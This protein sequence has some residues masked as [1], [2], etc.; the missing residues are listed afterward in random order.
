[1]KKLNLPVVTRRSAT[2]RSVTGIGQRARLAIFKRHA[3]LLILAIFTLILGGCSSL[4]KD[5]CMLANWHHIGLEDGREGRDNTYV[6]EHRSACNSHGVRVDYEAYQKGYRQG[7]E[8]FCRMTDH[9]EL[10]R[11]GE[12]RATQCNSNSALHA[13][14]DGL[15]L[16]CT[17]NDPFE[18]GL[19]G[20]SYNDVCD[21]G[22]ASAYYDG[23]EVYDL[24]SEREYLIHEKDELQEKLAKATTP[25][26]KNELRQEIKNKRKR[27]K[28]IKTEIIV[29][30][31]KNRI[32][33][34]QVSGLLDILSL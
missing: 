16:Y 2:G 34:D 4:S 19:R 6:S 18:L 23:Y 15:H 7:V 26:R 27:I 22:F 5:E 9:Y 12:P 25:E 1:M 24:K 14:E 21:S 10:G 32:G 29:L 28:R 8:E 31:T 11:A 20:A 3:F 30:I 17:H 13:Y 33:S